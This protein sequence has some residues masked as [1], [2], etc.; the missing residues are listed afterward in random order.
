[1]RIESFQTH[2]N[3]ASNRSLLELYE[4]KNLL[5]KIFMRYF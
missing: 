2:R 4:Y 1:V 5:K 3:S